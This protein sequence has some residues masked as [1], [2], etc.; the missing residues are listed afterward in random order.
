M[1]PAPPSLPLPISL[2][3]LR[4]CADDLAR[5]TD[6]LVQ[7]LDDGQANWRPGDGRGWSVAQ[8]LDHLALTSNTY[9]DAIEAAMR[10]APTRDAPLAAPVRPGWF[11][12]WFIRQ[13]EPPVRLRMPAPGRIVPAPRRAIGEAADAF[14]ASL[15]RYRTALGAA[16]RV[17]ANVLRFANPFAPVRF[18]VG[19]GLVVIVAHDRR[20]LWQAWNVKAAT[21]FP[22]RADLPPV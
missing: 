19:A 4:A 13:L 15:D 9:L 10:D 16:A 17:E 5:E 12:R 22:S 6:R 1:T 18:T 8:C 2:D 3:E 21:G 14:L 7:G 11:A 20:H